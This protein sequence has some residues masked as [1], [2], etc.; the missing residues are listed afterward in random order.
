MACAE[1]ACAEMAC[2]CVFRTT[3]DRSMTGAPDDLPLAGAP[4]DPES[5]G[6]SDDPVGRPEHE[7]TIR[8]MRYPFTAIMTK[9]GRSACRE[10][11]T[12]TKELLEWHTFAAAS[13][14]LQCGQTT[15]SQLYELVSE[16]EWR[17][18]A[19]SPQT[20]WRERVRH[21][22]MQRLSRQAT[23]AACGRAGR[24]ARARRRCRRRR[25]LC[26]R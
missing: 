12:T 15:R 4:S 22:C 23:R 16:Q 11:N 19:P 13:H 17:H 25:R 20:T 8:S 3:T 14:A 6:A 9:Y 5:D 26:R 24:L 21:T 10:C 1:M 18:K 7:V 2:Q